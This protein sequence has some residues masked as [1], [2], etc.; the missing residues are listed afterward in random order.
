MKRRRG[1]V[2]GGCVSGRIGGE[3]YGRRIKFVGLVMMT[4]FKV[5]LVISWGV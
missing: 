1:V 3:F 4:L 2:V 5:L